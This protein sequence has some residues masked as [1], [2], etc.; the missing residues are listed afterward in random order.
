VS[1]CCHSAVNVDSD[2]DVAAV[3]SENYDE[4]CMYVHE[5]LDLPV[6]PELMDHLEMMTV[7]RYSLL[8][9]LVILGFSLSVTCVR[10]YVH[11]PAQ[12]MQHHC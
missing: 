2:D 3:F 6:P 12:N 7:C 8:R 5:E 10:R 11:F 9:L 4:L 1:N